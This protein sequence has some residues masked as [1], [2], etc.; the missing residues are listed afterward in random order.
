MYICVHRRRKY[1]LNNIKN[2]SAHRGTETV[3]CNRDSISRLALE[4]I[5]K[6]RLKLNLA[7]E[8]RYAGGG[9]GALTPQKHDSLGKTTRSSRGSR[10]K[11]KSRYRHARTQSESFKKQSL[12]A[13]PSLVSGLVYKGGPR[14]LR[15][16]AGRRYTGFTRT[17]NKKILGCDRPT[18]I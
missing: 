2:A 12:C 7:S 18:R 4:S 9:A 5:R 1:F 16:I 17:L 3:L 6:T 10:E 15:A 11:G 8:S 13:H 14:E